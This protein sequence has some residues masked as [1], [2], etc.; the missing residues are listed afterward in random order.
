MHPDLTYAV[1]RHYEHD[2]RRHAEV[3]RRAADFKSPKH[4]LSQAALPRFEFGYRL[5]AI[6][7]IVHA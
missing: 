2:L 7:K 4:R 3:G 5:A 1:G 6:R